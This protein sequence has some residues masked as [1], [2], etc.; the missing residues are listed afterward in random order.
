MKK[1]I[2]ALCAL[3]FSVGVYAQN[4]QQAPAAATQQ[5]PKGKGGKGG[6]GNALKNA[7]VTPEEQAKL[8]AAREA[9]KAE[10]ETIKND[11]SLS[12]GDR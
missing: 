3:V 4:A 5:A 8:K 2:V 6:K 1:V 9:M 12:A 11:A 7:G 10:R